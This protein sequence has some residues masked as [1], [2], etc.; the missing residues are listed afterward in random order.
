MF[1]C[2]AALRRVVSWE[3]YP[4]VN[5]RCVVDANMIVLFGVV[6]TG[7]WALSRRQ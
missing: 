6:G 2:Q 3:E 5:Q 7:P 1:V 4:T